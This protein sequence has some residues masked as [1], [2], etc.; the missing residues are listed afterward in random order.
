[1]FLDVFDFD[2]EEGP[3]AGARL[4]EAALATLPSRPEYTRFVA[5]RWRD[6]TGARRGVEDRMEVLERLGAQLFVERL[7]LQWE[8]GTPI[9]APTGRLTFHPFH[10]CDEL[11]GLMTDV[12]TGTLDAHGRDEL[13]RMTAAE[14]ARRQYD[15][16]LTRYPSPAEWW[17]IARRPDGVPVGFVIPAHNGYNPV[18][19]YI[20]VVPAMR[21]NGYIDEILAEGT[22]ILAAQDVPRI[23]A[24]TDIGNVPMA[25]AFDRAGYV[26]FERQIDMVWPGRS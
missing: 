26:T 24:A 10:D 12:M 3:Q 14:A 9:P 7:R 2:G 6:D 13:V 11:V 22:R 23:R 15:E 16:E 21:G 8:P 1:M 19:A 25:R 5:P 4:L 17:R 18:I 20:G